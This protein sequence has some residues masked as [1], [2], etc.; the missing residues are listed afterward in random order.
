MP[1]H[2]LA[3]SLAKELDSPQDIPEDF[4]LPPSDLYSDEPPLENVRKIVGRNSRLCFNP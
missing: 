3:M 1:S 4:I 2:P